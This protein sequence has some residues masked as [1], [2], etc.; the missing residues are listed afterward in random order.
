MFKTAM[1]EVGLT[2]QC[3]PTFAVL[4]AGGWVGGGGDWSF[5]P[6]VPKPE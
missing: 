1:C 2:R 3:H 4:S 5:V 6:V